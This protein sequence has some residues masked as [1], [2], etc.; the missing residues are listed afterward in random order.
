M[1]TESQRIVFGESYESVTLPQEAMPELSTPGQLSGNVPLNSAFQVF[2]TQHIL[3]AMW[4]HARE[5]PQLECA[6]A[7]YGHPFVQPAAFGHTSTDIVFVVIAAAVPYETPERTQGHVRVTA[8]ALAAADAYV[9]QEHWGLQPVGWYHTHPGHGIFLS[10]YD[11]V[12]TR[13]IF[14]ASWH[15]AIVIDPLREQIGFFRGAEGTVLPGYRVLR[16]LPLEL[17]LMQIY[18]QGC[19][20]NNM[21]FPGEALSKFEEVQKLF[22]QRQ[23]DL[24]FWCQRDDY[25]DTMQWLAQLQPY[26]VSPPSP[27]PS[28]LPDN[29]LPSSVPDNV[30]PSSG[31]DNALLPPAE[32][33]ALPPNAVPDQYRPAARPLGEQVGDRALDGANGIVQVLHNLTNLPK[34]IVKGVRNIFP[35][36]K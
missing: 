15:V 16:S 6:G 18:N 21:N 11:L 35:D 17:T 30:L 31:P 3:D 7:L 12:I 13:G 20:L 8:E 36:K 23:A 22:Q 1:T 29:V 2:V 19:M 4:Q 25:R 34:T 10:G 33:S 9:R 26:V 5:T 24:P 14:N 27:H 28:S 32:S